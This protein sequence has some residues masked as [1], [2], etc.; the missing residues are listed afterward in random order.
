M[1]IDISVIARYR[2][3]G[4]LVDS[5]LLVAYLVGLCD[6]N[7]LRNCRATK[8]SFSDAEFDLLAGIIGQFDALITTPHVLT[9]VSNL[10]GKLP[11]QL[12]VKFRSFFSSVI[13]QLTEENVAA[14]KIAVEGNFVRFGIADTAISL[15]SPGRY[16]VL[17]EEVALY[18]QLAKNGVDV[19]N[20]SHVRLA[21]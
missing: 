4:I 5:S 13:G 21:A 1:S 14:A 12:H 8:S 15:I 18:A 19:L 16:L 17:T 9:E 3:K 11:E 10:A 2:T 6:R 20:F 7:L